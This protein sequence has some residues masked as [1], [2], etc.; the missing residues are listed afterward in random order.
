MKIRGILNNIGA[1]SKQAIVGSVICVATVAVGIGLMNNF[2]KSG[3][4]EQGFASNALERGG[5]YTSTY[6][7]ASAE[8]IL[9]AR[10]YAQNGGR[11]NSFSAITGTENLAIRRK[12]TSAGAAAEQGAVS[13]EASQAEGS[14]DNSQSYGAGELEGMG[15]SNKIAIDVNQEDEAA[16]QAQRNAK[17]AKGKTL[18]EQAKSSLKTSKM[19]D[20]SGIKGIESGSTSMTYGTLGSAASNARGGSVAGDS[21]K[22][23]LS[24][25]PLG[26]V[27]LQGAKA[28]KLSGMGSNGVEADGKRLGRAS[29]GQNYQ[30][31][32]DLGRASKYSKSGKQAVSSDRALG[33]SDAAAAFDGS[34]EAEAVN[35]DGENL[36][37]AALSNLKDMGA[38]DMQDYFDK[39]KSDI[40]E[41]QENMDKWNRLIEQ[42]KMCIQ[43]MLLIASVAAIALLIANKAGLFGLIPMVIICAIAAA[44]LLAAAIASNVILGQIADLAKEFDY[45]KA[46][47]GI[48][49]AGPWLLF[50]GLSGILVGS[51]FGLCADSAM[52][53]EIVM[54]VLAGAGTSGITTSIS[55]MI[56][57]G[58]N[59]KAYREAEKTAEEIK[60]QTDDL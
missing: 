16:A 4:S 45:I 8:D 59:V 32:G 7:G 52:I 20:G 18:G 40:Q 17:I 41:V 53:T 55:N 12:T 35:L 14:A 36:Q 54:S 37:A 15:T 48:E 26:N 30:S 3:S 22:M 21:S 46:P 19:A 10:E 11:E 2:S 47:T 49:W 39:L 25:A 51:M 57:H 28:G 9:S 6:T 60:K 13:A 42:Y 29:S 58:K 44:G 43:A 33:A 5:A 23:P 1:I 31:L 34:K 38:P 50:A 27:N 56:R 24:Q